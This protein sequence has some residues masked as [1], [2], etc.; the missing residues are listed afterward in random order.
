MT[1]T[2]N[3]KILNWMADTATVVAASIYFTSINATW[4]DSF[5]VGGAERLT[6]AGGL[7]GKEGKK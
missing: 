1:V 3:W 7:K 6:R 5:E 4:P 2:K